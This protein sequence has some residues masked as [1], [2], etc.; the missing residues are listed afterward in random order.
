[1]SNRTG[2]AKTGQSIA[3]NFLSKKDIEDDNGEVEMHPIVPGLP[4]HFVPFVRIRIALSLCRKI[5]SDAHS[6][7]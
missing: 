2:L 5:E 3:S 7:E 1:M 6:T 4:K